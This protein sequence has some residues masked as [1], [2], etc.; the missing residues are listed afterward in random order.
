MFLLNSPS[1]HLSAAELSSKSE[2]SHLVQRTFSRSYGTFLPSSFTRVLSSA[3]VSST[4]PPVSVWG[5]ACLIF[6]LGAFPGSLATTASGNFL[7]R[8]NSQIIGTCLLTHVPTYSLSP[9]LPSLRQPYLLRH[10]IA[11]KHGTGIL[12]RFPS[13]TLFSLALGTD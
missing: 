1:H 12:T 2:S 4:R 5:T 6:R 13:T 8:L 10:P 9:E 11:M 3:L 7:P